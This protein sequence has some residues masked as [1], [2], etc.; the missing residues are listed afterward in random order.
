VGWPY[1]SMAVHPVP[2]RSTPERPATSRSAD[3][4]RA[5]AIRPGAPSTA[6]SK[7]SPVPRTTEST[8]PRVSLFGIGSTTRFGRSHRC[9]RPPDPA[10]GPTVIAHRRLRARTQS[11]TSLVRMRAVV[12]RQ[13]RNQ[14]GREQ[15]HEQALMHLGSPPDRSA[16]CQGVQ[17]RRRYQCPGNVF[18]CQAGGTARAHILKK[19][20]G[21]MSPFCFAA[22]GTRFPPGLPRTGAKALAG[23]WSTREV[24]W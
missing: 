5:P 18:R 8:A 6:R 20:P 19:H 3:E 11:D 13:R 14:R 9:P 4:H 16:G 10:A 2:P 21:R 12:L 7:M 22:L 17:P 1:M 15:L 23:S 24:T